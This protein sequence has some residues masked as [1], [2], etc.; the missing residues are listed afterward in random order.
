MKL[1]ARRNRSIKTAMGDSQRANKAA[2]DIE[3]EVRAWEQALE[4]GRCEIIT[5][6]PLL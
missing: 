4:T 5:R 6:I 2:A 3:A 1:E